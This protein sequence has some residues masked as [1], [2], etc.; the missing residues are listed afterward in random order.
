[1]VL[2]RSTLDPERKPG[3]KRLLEMR[4]KI[5]RLNA[6]SVFSEPQ[7]EPKLVAT[8]ANVVRVAVVAPRRLLRWARGASPRR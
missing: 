8:I 3:V 4:K 6:R 5:K 1:M 2:G 7:F